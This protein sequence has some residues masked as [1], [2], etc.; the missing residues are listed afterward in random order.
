MWRERKVRIES[1]TENLRLLCERED[2]VKRD[3]TK[4]A[5]QILKYLHFDLRVVMM[6][7]GVRCKESDA[8]LA[9]GDVE[10]NLFSP[11]GDEREIGV[12][13]IDRSVDVCV[14]RGD[15]KVVSEG[16]FGALKDR[17]VRDVEVEQCRAED[18]S[19]RNAEVDVFEG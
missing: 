3:M 16:G 15:R 1:D 9:G 14:G 4:D 6:L 12:Q 17:E 18:G 8:G 2:A 11:S 13:T 7:M 10:V 19:L 5:T